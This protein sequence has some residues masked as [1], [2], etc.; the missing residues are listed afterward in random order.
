MRIGMLLKK[1]RLVNELSIR[2]V[3]EEVGIGA[4]TLYK[5]ETGKPIDAT[6]QLKLFNWLFAEEVK[7]EKDG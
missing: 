5:I 2:Q 7:G 1:W 4:A 3:A 6:T